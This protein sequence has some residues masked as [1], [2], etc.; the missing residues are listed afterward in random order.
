MIPKNIENWLAGMSPLAY[1]LGMNILCVESLV[2]MKPA[3]SP[4]RPSSAMLRPVMV[5]A[6]NIAKL[7]RPVA[8]AEPAP[9]GSK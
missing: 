1:K 5:V 9:I 4:S 8:G 2:P 3:D 6:R 7:V